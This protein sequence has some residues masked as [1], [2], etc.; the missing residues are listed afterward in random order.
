MKPG[1]WVAFC[2]FTTG[3]F[4]TAAC[5]ERL[6]LLHA[7]QSEFVNENGREIH[8]LD[9]NVQF[10]QGEAYLSCQ[11]AFFD[12]DADRITLMN[13]VEIYDGKHRLFSDRAVYEGKTKTEKAYHHV[14]LIQDERCLQADSV[15]YS[16]TTRQA[17]AFGN[18]RFDDLVEHAAL[19]GQVIHYDRNTDYG[20]ATGDPYIVQVDT[21]GGDSLIIL[22]RRLEGWGKNKLA[23][24][25]D[26]VRIV[27]GGMHAVSRI[28]AYHTK[29][30]RLMLYGS[31]EMFENNRTLSGD[32]IQVRLVDS[33]F[34]GG[35]IYGHAVITSGDSVWQD[36]LTG[37]L[38]TMTTEQDTN[39]TVVVEKE[40]QNKYHIFNEDGSLE[41][42]NDI[43][44][45]RITLK[46]KG[47]RLAY[48]RV[49]SSPAESRGMFTPREQIEP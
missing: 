18:A 25:T 37:H 30:E 23:V 29:D 45:D 2:I 47:S 42:V 34:S 40:A 22:G 44:G 48:V 32:S 14:R 19:C 39:R 27:K 17:D 43:N 4:H 36:I 35:I 15:F 38:I 3:L 21:A 13:G 8:R 7:D 41:G 6:E 20:Y 49:E 31:P 10:R 1:T 33:D 26:S 9:G 24:V 12:I 5:R 46:F 16:Q 28:A 11:T